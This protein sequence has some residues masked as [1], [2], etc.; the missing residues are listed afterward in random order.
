MSPRT[1]RPIKGN[2]R[3]DISLQMRISKSTN[4]K[5]QYCSETLEKSRTEVVEQGIDIIYDKLK[6]K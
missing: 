2:E 4:D 5:L 3:K 6:K 1:G